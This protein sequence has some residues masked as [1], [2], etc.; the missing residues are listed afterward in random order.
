MSDR[1]FDGRRVQVIDFDDAISDERVI[2]FR[3]P[4]LS[5]TDSMIMVFNS[6]S[7]WSSAQVAFSPRVDSLPAPFVLWALAVARDIT[8]RS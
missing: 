5:P 3:D 6:G 8:E 1:L 4:D 7:D 2:E